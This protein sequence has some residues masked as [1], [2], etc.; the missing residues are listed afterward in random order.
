ML[1]AGAYVKSI[2]INNER[3][4]SVNHCFLSEISSITGRG[5]AQTS[6]FLSKK[7]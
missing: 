1:P 7:K 3:F 4:I 5:K 2:K 6:D